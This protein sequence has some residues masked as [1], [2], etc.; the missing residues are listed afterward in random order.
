M[1]TNILAAMHDTIEDAGWMTPETKKKAVE[2]LSAVTVKVGYPNKWRNYSGVSITR[3]GYFEDVLAAERFQ[4]AYDHA[5]IGKPVDRS[6][7]EMTPP[8]SNAAYYNPLLNEIVFPAGILQP[9]AF[10]VD[11]T[12][13]VNYGAIGVVIG[14]EISHGFD[15]QGA[16]FDGQ[17]RLQNWWN[18]EDLKQF[19]AKTAC[20]VH[21]F[22]GYTIADDIHINGRLVL[23]ESIGDLG[24]VKIAYLAFQKSLQGKPPAPTISGFTPDQQFFIAWGQFRSDAIRPET[25]KK[26]VQGDPHPVAKFRVIGPLSNYPPFAQ[27]FSCKAGSAMVRPES[28]RCVV[29]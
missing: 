11:V 7:W 23:G 4:T 16:Q 20:V 21:Q 9:P 25:Q 18:Q 22:D 15:D 28:E 10:S 3:N 19:Q 12:D 24:G 1:V 14:H 2:K 27:T 17:G 5:K 26:M 6:L 13:A 8:T 29:W